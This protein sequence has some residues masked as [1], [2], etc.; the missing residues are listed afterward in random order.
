MA[1]GASDRETEEEKKEM[2][3]ESKREEARGRLLA[4]HERKD[5]TQTAEKTGVERDGG[6][7]V[8][9]ARLFE[10]GCEYN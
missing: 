5:E 10:L 2:S 8:L 3:D 4:S 7:G 9:A 1:E 6:G